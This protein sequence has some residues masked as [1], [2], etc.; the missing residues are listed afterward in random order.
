MTQ[1]VNTRA[2]QQ[3][4]EHTIR[5]TLIVVSGQ[6]ILEPQTFLVCSMPLLAE[7]ITNSTRKQLALMKLRAPYKTL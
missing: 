4:A 5:R 3:L 6:V 2:K 7:I 1:P